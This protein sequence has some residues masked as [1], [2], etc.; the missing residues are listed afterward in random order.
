MMNVKSLVTS[1]A[2]GILTLAG[3]DASA[4]APNVTV[5]GFDNGRVRL[6]RGSQRAEINLG[7]DISGCKGRL[8]DPM[9]KEESENGL[10]FEVVDETVKAP[11]TYVV[12]LASASPNCNVQGACGA[13]G[14]DSTLLW[15]KLTRDLKLAGKKAVVFEQCS[16]N[17][18]VRL[19][20]KKG[21][22]GDGADGFTGIK[23]RDLSW[24]GD[25]LR[26][27]YEEGFQEPVRVQ[28]VVYDRRNPEAGL[29][30]VAVAGPHGM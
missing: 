30:V 26:I 10:T 14:P 24:M 9:T 29:T 19:E 12:L 27:E 28:S 7:P 4:E 18:Q 16:T 11:Y 17:R 8:H 25:V 15:L 5:K 3:G 23:A 6:V 20:K 1:L 22:T 2:I 13:G 21:S